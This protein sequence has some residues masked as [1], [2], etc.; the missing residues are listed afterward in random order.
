[1]LLPPGDFE[2]AGTL[3][4]GLCTG[5][6]CGL[7]FSPLDRAAWLG[8]LGAEKKPERDACF[9][10]LMFGGVARGFGDRLVGLFRRRRCTHGVHHER[11]RCD[12]GAKMSADRSNR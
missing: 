9:S 5:S 1:M 12:V 7:E 6:S 10:V 3:G 11:D 2:A 8:G 4:A